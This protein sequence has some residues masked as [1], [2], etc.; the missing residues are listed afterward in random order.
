MDII[1]GLMEKTNKHSE[2]KTEKY[3]I[4][5]CQKTFDKFVDTRKII[6]LKNLIKDIKDL[7]IF[8]ASFFESNIVIKIG[9]ADT[10]EKEYKISHILYNQKNTLNLSNKYKY[11][12]NEKYFVKYFCYFA[13]KNKLYNVIQNSSVCSSDGDEIKIL[14]MKKYKNGN[15][16]NY[17]WNYDN[18]ILLKEL[19]KE[20]FYSL[21]LA[22]KNYGF[23]HNNC[24]FG[25]FLISNNHKVIIID[26][27]NSLFD[28]TKQNEIKYVYMS[29]EQIISNILYELN[30]NATNINNTLQYLK[31]NE[32][33]EIN[34]LLEY[35]DNIQFISK[36]DKTKLIKYDPNI[37]F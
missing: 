29:F 22:Y 1:L 32:N 18:F 27:E 2:T 17:D 20:I 16:K 14:I 33:I 7:K 10:I 5:D 4:L 34:T 35:V 19:I 8:E 6:N 24:H 3:E 11:L 13:C 36:Y 30:I 23:I 31:Q 15:I 9:L 26:F 37:I 28:L 21:L 25:N 12:E